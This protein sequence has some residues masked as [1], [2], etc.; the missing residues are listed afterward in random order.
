MISVMFQ[1]VE[2]DVIPCKATANVLGSVD[3]NWASMGL[4]VTNVFH[5]LDANTAD[6]IPR[7]LNVSAKKDGTD[8]SVQNV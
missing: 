5:F 8:F 7:P 3:A 6:A 2:R 4:S 1:Y